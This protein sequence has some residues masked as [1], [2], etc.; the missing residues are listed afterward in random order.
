MGN[1]IAGLDIGTSKACVIVGERNEQ[2]ALEIAGLGVCPSDG[3]RKGV[4]VNIEATRRSIISAVEN[5]ETNSGHEIREVYTGIGGNNIDGINC[6]GV[7]RIPRNDNETREIGRDDILRVIESARTLRHPMD[8]K[9]L[10]VIPQSY[11]VDGQSGIRNPLDM[12]GVRL[13]ADVLIITCSDTSFQNLIRCVNRAGY[14]V[15]D[16]IL[17]SLAASRAVLTEEEKEWGVAMVDLG[18]GTTDIM[19]YSQ[20]MPFYTK[21][22]QIGGDLITNDISIMEKISIETAETMKVQHGCC[23]GELIDDNEEIVIENSAGGAPSVVTRKELTAIIQPRIIEIFRK[24]KEEL[25]ALPQKRSLGRGIV[26]TGGGAELNGVSEL[27]AQ[28]FKMPVRV[29]APLPVIGLDEEFR[30]PAY[31]PAI[32]L[33]F[34]GNDREVKGID[35]APVKTKSGLSVGRRLKEW[36]TKE[37]L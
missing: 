25:D 3:I 32:G 17:Q 33:A 4:V 24:V 9:E 12:L 23:W 26:L 27:A 34:L 13:E 31:A 20:G 35:A 5:A 15:K 29:G 7:A 28:I 2:G 6:R 37:V 36:F 18:G 22:I 8:R 10:E 19:V 21:N 14:T 16:M 1:I 30:R 11:T